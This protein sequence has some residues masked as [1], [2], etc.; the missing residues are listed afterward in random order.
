MPLSHKGRFVFIHVPKVAGTSLIRSFEEADLDLDFMGINLWPRLGATDRRI[1]IVRKLRSVFPV[2]TIAGF[3]E[4]HMPAVVL[5]EFLPPEMWEEYFKFAF[6]RNPWDLVVSTYHFFQQYP[7]AMAMDP[8]YRFVVE[9]LDFERFVYLYPTLIS[10]MSSMFCDERGAPIVD[11]I[12]RFETMEEDFSVISQRIGID[13]ELQHVNAS[14]RSSYRDYYSDLSRS[15][16]A[17][18]FARDIER[19]GYEF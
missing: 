10:D 9:Y 6:V 7:A 14:R 11:Y 2:N 4:Q 12:G 3:A 15:V 16:V 8:D 17:S 18:H 13:V 5:R 1:E 19:F